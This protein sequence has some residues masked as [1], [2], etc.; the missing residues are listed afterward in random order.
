LC[1]TSNRVDP[2]VAKRVSSVA[3]AVCRRIAFTGVPNVG[4][5]FPKLAGR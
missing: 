5:R 2:A 3:T 4:C 1:V